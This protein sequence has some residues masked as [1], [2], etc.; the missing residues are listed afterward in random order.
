[1]PVNELVLLLEPL[2]IDSQ[3]QRSY[4]I[5]E[6]ASRRV[7]KAHKLAWLESLGNKT[8]SLTLASSRTDNQL[9]E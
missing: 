9:F 8:H 2:D 3:S 1:M 6:A 7:Y 4:S 5:R